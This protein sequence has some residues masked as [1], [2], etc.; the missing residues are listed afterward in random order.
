M[1]IPHSAVESTMSFHQKLY[2]VKR[3]GLQEPVAFDKIT[4][5]LQKL[6]DERQDIKDVDVCLVAQKVIRGIFPGVKTTELDTLSA[7]T[8]AC[9]GTINP[10]YTRLAAA[11]AVSN[12]HKET[13]SSVLETFTDMYQN[14]RNS[15]PAPLITEE[16]WSIVQRN[17]ETLQSMVDY[18]RDYLFDYF[19]FKTLCRSYLTRLSNNTIVE[20]PQHMYLRVALCL[21]ESDLEKVRETYDLMSQHFFTHATPTLFNAGKMN[22]NL[23]SCFLSV[24]KADSIE[25]IFD[26]LKDCAL[27]SKHAGGV[28]L[29][30]DN[31]RPAGSYIAG[32]GGY[33]N[34]ILPMLKV[35]NESAKYVDQCFASDTEVFTHIGTRRI[36]HLKQGDLV[37][38]GKGNF[39]KVLSVRS[40][41]F[42]P[43]VHSLVSVK[44]AGSSKPV[45]MSSMHQIR[46][47]RDKTITHPGSLPLIDPDYCDAADIEPGH[48]VAFPRLR[49]NESDIPEV[50]LQR[51]QDYGEA[52]SCPEALV[53][54]SEYDTYF[55][56]PAAKRQR[57]L[58]GWI[59]GVLRF[60]PD[61]SA[62]D[63]RRLRFIQLMGMSLGVYITDSGVQ[64]EGTIVSDTDVWVKVQS[65]EHPAGL[66][67][68]QVLW[69]LD[70]E[71]DES[72]VVPIGDAHNGGGKRKGSYAV[73]LSM[74]HADIETFIPMR[75]KGPDEQ[76]ALD[77]FYGL[78]IPDIFMERVLKNEPWSLF[79]PVDAPG[80]ND[81]Y[82]DAYRDLYLEYE[83]QGKARKKVQ[84][85]DLWNLIKASQIETGMPY[86]LYKD[87]CNAK[88]NQRNLG[89]IKSSNLCVH[90]KTSINARIQNV[91][92]G[93][94]HVRELIEHAIKGEKVE[95][96][97]GSGFSSMATLQSGDSSFQGFHLHNLPELSDK[98]DLK[99]LTSA[100]FSDI[101]RAKV[102]TMRWG[103]FSISTLAELTKKGEVVEVWNGQRYTPTEVMKTGAAKQLLTLMFDVANVT[104]EKFTK[105]RILTTE[106]EPTS[107]ECTPE[108]VFYLQG[109]TRVTAADLK[110]GDILQDST[111]PFNQVLQHTLRS[112]KKNAARSDVYCFNERDR[113]MGVFNGILAGNCTEIIEYT[114]PDEI[115]VCNLASISL[116]HFVKQSPSGPVFDFAG[117]H[118]IAKI[119]TYNLNRTIDVGSY[120]VPEAKTSN[121]R[122]RPIG[123]GVQGLADTFFMMRYPFTSDLARDLNIKIF[124]TIY[125]AAVETSVELAK[126]EGP[127]ETFKGS[128]ASEGLLQFDLWR[129]EHKRFSKYYSDTFLN[130]GSEEWMKGEVAKL[131]GMFD[132]AA[133][134][135]DVKAHG[136][137]NSLL[138][139]PMPTA[140]TAQ[141][142]GNSECFEPCTSNMYVR[143]V[144]AGDFIMVNHHLVKDLIE[145]GIWSEAVADKIKEGNGSV[146]H[147]PEIP[148]DLKEL[149]RTVWETPTSQLIDM[150]IDRA[151]FVDQSMSFNNFVPKNPEAI[152]DSIHF[153]GWKRGLKTGQYYLRTQPAADPIKFTL[154]S[155]KSS[156][157]CESCSA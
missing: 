111:L 114:S 70:V 81:V 30:I 126:K 143:R 147:I 22:P 57:V 40:Y 142:L 39:R 21:H 43:T 132:W 152:L 99:I 8:L 5:R 65:V 131:S 129:M 98:P 91:R 96:W 150:A 124:E 37:L 9:M 7:E 102:H 130:G 106:P 62:L 97:D 50:T 28:G 128:P 32:T 85:R 10:D 17:H 100:G 86:M 67:G 155:Q 20:R 125:H 72:Y 44:L 95:V 49:V 64:L 4:A 113:H 74:H 75:M 36:C 84:A 101:V 68:E 69:D 33:S 92:D 14:T 41:P 123:I 54:N 63:D 118:R 89:T 108:H 134:K 82:G 79:C 31:I 148:A 135:E 83:R 48:L 18:G 46:L 78:W 119:V 139:A 23:A 117:L 116:R 77:L 45:I 149:Y 12:H 136:M 153:K 19:G 47:V 25:G 60:K 59:A 105:K 29:S 93:Q 76:R 35:F 146:Q 104:F 103:E 90:P 157:Q 52:L 120:P 115:A 27:I 56:L 87:H 112:V 88:S 6:V 61:I 151:P 127:Y 34:G 107:L 24:I 73:Y 80:L 13:K 109:G 11:V 110:P 145:R 15:T 94:Y 38:T 71:T 144:L 154:P 3:N 122:H 156:I 133:L 53:R 42:N 26:T 1:S 51:C 66:P 138:V 141:I 16:I 121:L 2:V 58:D 137:R 140:S 55:R